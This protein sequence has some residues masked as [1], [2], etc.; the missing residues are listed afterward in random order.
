[1][2]NTVLSPGTDFPDTPFWYGS[3]AGKDDAGKTYGGEC[4]LKVGNTKRIRFVDK[5]NSPVKN[6]TVTV[7]VSGEFTNYKKDGQELKPSDIPAKP[8]NTDYTVNVTTD[9]DG[10]GDIDFIETYHYSN[11]G[12]TGLAQRV[13]YNAVSFSTEGLI[14]GA[15]QKTFT[16]LDAE[17][18][19]V[20]DIKIKSSLASVIVP[21]S[22]IIAILLIAAALVVT[23]IKKE[24]RNTTKNKGIKP[25][26]KKIPRKH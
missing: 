23:D 15:V 11:T 14:G 18:Q 1:M 25:P 22:V 9:K 21:I 4:D 7:K 16:E 5:N 17:P 6:K 13:D 2:L 26:L 3:G 12:R 10:Y 8:F 19:V 20:L 24:K